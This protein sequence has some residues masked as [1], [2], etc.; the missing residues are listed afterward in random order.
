MGLTLAVVIS[1][2]YPKQK[3][4]LIERLLKCGLESSNGI[5]N[6]GTG[7]AGYCELNYTPQDKKNRI[8]IEKALSINEM[9]ESSLQFWAYLAD[10]HKDFDC[11]K[12]LNKS[13]H[14]SFVFGKK[15]IRF[16]KKRFEKLKDQP[17]FQGMQYTENHKVIKNWV[18]L[19][20]Q[21]RSTKQKVAATKIDHG[22]DINFGE[23]CKQLLNVLRK[24]KQ[25]KVIFDSNISQIN[26]SYGNSFDLKY[27]IKKTNKIKIVSSKKVFIGSGGQAINMLQN[28]GINEIKGYAGF[29]LSGEW[30]VCDKQEII[31]QHQA[32]VYSLPLPGAPAMSI[33]HLDLR[34]LGEKK[35]L[36]FGPFASITTKFLKFGSIWD[37]FKSIK[38]N[39]IYSLLVIFYNNLPLLKYLIY[40]SLLT[41]NKKMEQLKKFYPSANPNDWEKKQAGQRV[42]IIKKTNN[43]INLEFGTEI[44]YSSQKNLIGLIGA[45]PG[46]STSS[47][48][49]FEIALNIYDDPNL[50]TKIKK[51]VPLYNDNLNKNP[52]LLKKMRDIVYKKL[53]LF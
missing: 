12:F 25:F 23:L 1:E 14:I 30:L 38:L 24:N 11:S 34:I 8:N 37:F 6:A 32:K 35:I 3:I 9:F 43:S 49:M 10:K 40:Q 17:L 13:A 26:R 45:S 4:L 28:I 44:I 52:K 29:P 36:L 16:L 42:Q 15:N 20:M 33:P 22:T 51:M 7:H 46:A 18:P 53:K 50:L 27:K 48:L 21:E 39:N 41:H 31:K 5:N 19:I 47:Y 2:I